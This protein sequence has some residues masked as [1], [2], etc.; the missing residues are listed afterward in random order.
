MLRR[1]V[2]SYPAVLLVGPPGTGKGTLLLW[3]FS[4]IRSDPAAFGMEAGPDPAPMWRTPDESWTAYELVGGLAPEANGELSWTAG[5]LPNAIAENRWLVLDETNRADMDKIMGPLLT[6]LSGQEVEVGRTLAH[7]GQP[8]QIGWGT[9]RAST[10]TEGDQRRFLA[11]VDWR[12]LGTYNPQDAQL[13]FRFGVALARRFAQVPVPAIDRGQF[14]TLLESQHPGLPVDAATAIADLYEAHLDADE[15]TLGPAVFLRLAQYLVEGD[16]LAKVLAEAYLVNV[17][18]YLATY[19][20]ATF[21]SLRNR[22]VDERG[23][24][25]PDEWA[26]LAEQRDTLG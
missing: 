1:A 13:V 20:D 17:G 2:A 18:K 26:W 22:V 7:G 19:D 15:T 5:A 6:W 23:T 3:L 14:E 25:M 10:V 9:D 12:L 11:G 4:E 16:D 8:V 21:E 24:L